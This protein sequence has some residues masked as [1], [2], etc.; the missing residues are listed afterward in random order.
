MCSELYYVKTSKSL[1]AAKN[2]PIMSHFAEN[3]SRVNQDK[4]IIM[5]HYRLGHPKFMYIEKLFPHLFINKNLSL[6]KYETCQ[7]AKHTKSSYLIIP[8]KPSKPFV[9]IHSD[10]WGPSKI[11][12]I[13]GARLISITS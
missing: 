7:L 8:Y 5:W 13:N 12:N 1:I 9:L 10:I 4:D 11:K 3:D 2:Y 6:F